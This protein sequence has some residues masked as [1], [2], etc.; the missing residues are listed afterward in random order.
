MPLRELPD[1]AMVE[2]GAQSFLVAQ[3]RVL[4]WTPGGYREPPK[5]IEAAL[6]LTPPSTLRALSSGYRPLLHP[7]AMQLIG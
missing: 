3:G 5:A 2:E 7:S 6:L 4:T 1:G